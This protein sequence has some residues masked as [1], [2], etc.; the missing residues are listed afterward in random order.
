M[1]RVVVLAVMIA[2]LPLACGKVLGKKDPAS[3]DTVTTNDPPPTPLPSATTPPIWNP[4]PTPSGAVP[5]AP[6][7]DP[8]TIDLT[9]AQAAFDA[10]DFKKAKTILERHVKAGKCVAD[11]VMLLTRACQQ[12][13]DKTCVADTKKACPPTASTPNDEPQKNGF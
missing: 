8:S 13:K 1:T 11:E 4:N 5:T 9:K 12:L 6:V 3:E 2:A 7:I 10:K